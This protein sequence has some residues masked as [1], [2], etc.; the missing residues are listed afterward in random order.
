MNFLSEREVNPTD[1]KSDHRHESD[2]E[3]NS[4]HDDQIASPTIGQ[5]VSNSR[6]PSIRNKGNTGPKGVL[7]DFAEFKELKKVEAQL[8]NLKLEWELRKAAGPALSL[9]TP[10]QNRDVKFLTYLPYH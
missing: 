9:H 4:S 6:E 2:E 8:K 1:D 5:M 10:S 3:S 7:A